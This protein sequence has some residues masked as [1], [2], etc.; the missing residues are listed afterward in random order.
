LR[1]LCLM[2]NQ[3]RLRNPCGS[4]S[5]G[6]RAFERGGVVK[7]R[8]AES[9]PGQKKAPDCPVKLKTWGKIR[10]QDEKNTVQTTV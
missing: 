1:L 3:L 2:R 9:S 5:L 7:R 4:P 10:R 6:K 8:D